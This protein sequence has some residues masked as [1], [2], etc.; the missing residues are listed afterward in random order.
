M[1]FLHHVVE[2]NPKNEPESKNNTDR[3][4]LIVQKL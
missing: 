1:K 3:E 2:R 4:Q